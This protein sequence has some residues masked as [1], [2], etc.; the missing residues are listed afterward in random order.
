MARKFKYL[1]F[2]WYI[3]FLARKCKWDIFA[4]IFKHCV[5]WLC[6]FIPD[7]LWD[8]FEIKAFFLK[9]PSIRLLLMSFRTIALQK[10]ELVLIS[11]KTRIFQFQFWTSI[12]GLF[13][14]TTNIAEKTKSPENSTHLR[15]KTW[16]WLIIK[17]WMKLC[18]HEKDW[19]LEPLMQELRAFLEYEGSWDERSP[20]KKNCFLV[21]S[22]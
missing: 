1:P 9:A 19:G 14:V 12:F 4:V 15:R 10:I 22:N 21:F 6:N 11:G 18:L 17:S 3:L 5:F 7:W 2:K 8:F 20:A 16:M 13:L